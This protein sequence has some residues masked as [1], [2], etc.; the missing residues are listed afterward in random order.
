[1]VTMSTVQKKVRRLPFLQGILP[2][3]PS[4]IPMFSN[5]IDDVRKELDRYGLTKLIGEEHIYVSL[6]DVL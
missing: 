1:M 2:I 4:Q 3:V 5:V 6:P